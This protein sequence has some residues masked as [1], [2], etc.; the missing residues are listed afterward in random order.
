MP[1]ADLYAEIDESLY[2]LLELEETLPLEDVLEYVT[3]FVLPFCELEEDIVPPED[4]LIFH[5]PEAAS[6]EALPLPPAA[7]CASATLA[8]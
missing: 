5:V 4:V 7:C 1:P 8:A 3:V 2:D 6:N